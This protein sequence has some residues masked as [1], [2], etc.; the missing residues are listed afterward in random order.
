[1]KRL[2]ALALAA[3]MVATLGGC[4]KAKKEDEKKET[5]NNI[6]LSE[7]TKLSVDWESDYNSQL[8]DSALSAYTT[9]KKVTDRAI[10]QGDVANIDYAGYKDGVAFDGGTAQGQDLEIGSG[11]FI[12]GFEEGLVGVKPGKTVDLNLTFPENYGSADLAGQ[13]VVFTV[14]V[15]YITERTASEEDTLQAKNEIWGEAV[16]NQVL[17]K[18]ECSDYPQDQV[19]YFRKKYEELYTSMATSNGYNSLEEFYTAVGETE[20]SFNKIIKDY[21][22]HSVKRQLVAEAIA[23]KEGIEVTD[24]EYK[25]GVEKYAADNQQTAEEFEEA[26]EKSLIESELLIEEVTD[27]L[28]KNSTCK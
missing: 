17:E 26:N 3:L 18:S 25:S 21:A 15:N 22:E 5:S 1:M 12:P 24:K 16:F 4:K 7:Y 10:K 8:L 23:E 11:Q 13:D 27:F 9:T 28:A 20:E 19:D 6:E 2:A 14:T